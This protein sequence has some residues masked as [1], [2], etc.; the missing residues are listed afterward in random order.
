MEENK[1]HTKKG[2][3]S[4]ITGII[5]TIL[6]IN[7]IDIQPNLLP[8]IFGIISIITGITAKKEKDT[9]GKNGITLGILATIIG[10]LQVAA[11]YIYVYTSMALN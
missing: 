7:W 2:K 5:G 9:F 8:L 10:S 4:I 3:I 6:I 1:K 11:W